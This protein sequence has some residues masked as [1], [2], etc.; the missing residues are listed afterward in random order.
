MKKFLIIYLGALVVCFIFEYFKI[1]IFEAPV[2]TWNE[3][4]PTICPKHNLAVKKLP[5]TFAAFAI[6]TTNHKE[7]EKV[8]TS[9]PSISDSNITELDC[10]N[11]SATSL[12]TNS[13]KK[14]PTYERAFSSKNL[15]SVLP[16]FSYYRIYYD[17][18][19]NLIAFEP[20]Q[21]QQENPKV[22]FTC[23]YDKFGNLFETTV[24]TDISYL[25]YNSKNELKLIKDIRR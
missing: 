5:Q 8:D 25:V 11:I 16:N 10:S 22:E 9:L 15:E 4:Y 12:N 19:G 13:R 18:K 17:L 20:M 23:R 21:F 14:I 1:T 6:A 3:P 24:K 2:P 7:K